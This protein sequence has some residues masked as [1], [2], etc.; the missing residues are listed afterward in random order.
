MPRVPARRQIAKAAVP[1]HVQMLMP[2]YRL[3]IEYDG[4]PYAGWQRQDGH[5]VQ[6]A[7]EKA[8]DL[9]GETVTLRA[10]GRTDSGV[11]ATARS[12][13]STRPRT[14]RPY[15]ANAFNAHLTWRAR[16]SAIIEAKASA[17]ISMRVFRPRPALSLP[18]H[19]PSR[20]ARAGGERA[21]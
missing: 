2:R 19:Q 21:W 14:G 13:M 3:D 9:C 7:I 17:T 8:I 5:T 18:H 15:R 12:R 16:P 10:A 6:G 20:A 4:T 11:H 1:R